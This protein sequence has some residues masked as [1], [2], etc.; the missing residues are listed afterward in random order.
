MYKFREFPA[1]EASGTPKGH[2]KDL[3]PLSLLPVTPH[4]TI[5]T[6]RIRIRIGWSSVHPLPFY[7]YFL[8]YLDSVS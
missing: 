7:I 8:F 6:G 2:K 1:A 4:T 5:R 3:F